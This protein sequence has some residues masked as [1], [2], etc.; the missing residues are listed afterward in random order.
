MDITRGSEGCQGSETNLLK[1]FDD[2]DG[3]APEGGTFL[4]II[5]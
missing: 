1:L 3:V 2:N 5:S 4:M